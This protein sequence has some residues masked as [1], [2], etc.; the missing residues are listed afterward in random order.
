MQRSNTT[1]GTIWRRLIR[2]E[3][4]TLSAAVA[5]ALLRI[6]F[7]ESDRARMEDL[8]QRNQRGQ[9]SRGEQKE[10]RSFVKVGDVLGILHS[11]ARQALKKGN[12]RMKVHG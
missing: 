10:L 5:R 4:N 8:A 6:S 12:G 1:E 11:K 3:Q 7:S 2:P 9:L